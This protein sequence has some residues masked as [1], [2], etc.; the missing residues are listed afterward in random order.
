VAHNSKHFFFFFFFFGAHSSL[1][2]LA[3]IKDTFE[4]TRSIVEPAGALGVA[5]AKKYILEKNITNGTFVSVCSGANMN[6]DRLRFVADRADLG[7]EKEALIT[8]IVPE[9]PGSFMS[10]Y[11]TIHPRSVTEFSY[12][13]GDPSQATIFMSFKVDEREQEL[14]NIF[15]DL[16]GIG[17]KGMDASTNGE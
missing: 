17:M 14:E 2:N 9:K 11:K 13:Y 5:G 3:A 15:K 10:L 16:D 12:R 8:V 7:E 6:F 4:D 1:S